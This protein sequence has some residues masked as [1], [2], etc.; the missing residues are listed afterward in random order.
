MEQI[1]ILHTNDLH[2]HFENWPRI[3]RYL[4]ATQREIQEQ[5]QTVLT[6][7]LGDH[8][9][10]VHPLTEATGGHINVQLLNQ[11]HYDGVTIGNNEGLGFNHA[12]LDHLYDNANFDVI[13]GDIRDE[14]TNR[15]P[16]WAID[17]KLI[18]EPSGTRILV[19]GLTAPYLLTYP[20]VGWRPESVMAAL[21]ELLD[22]YRD[23]AD[24]CIL[25]S[26]LGLD[27]D[28]QI[29]KRFPQIQIIIGSHTHH[30]LENGEVVNDSLL[31]AAGKWGEYVGRIDLSVDDQHQL[32]SASAS[33]TAVRTLPVLAEDQSEIDHYEELGEELLSEREIA[34]LPMPMVA[35]PKGQPQIITVGLQAIAEY[36]HTDAAILNSGLFLSGLP[37]G[38]V[39]ANQL[40]Q[41]LPHA[42]HVMKVTLTGYDVW[43]LVNEME[44]CRQFLRHFPIK[45]MGFRGKIFGEINYLGIQFDETTGRVTW[46]GEDLNPHRRYTIAMLDNYLFIPFFPTIKLVGTAE[47]LFNQLLRDVVGH[48]LAN[49]YPI[50]GGRRKTDGS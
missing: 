8:C 4:Q 44:S 48:Y 25:L 16:D 9:D 6:F 42:I 40:H 39:N 43:R 38:I 29:A 34:A 18:T 14:K 15:V 21:S 1:T 45:G 49:H 37:E 22:A 13:L 27:V 47:I 17:H 33:V 31:A 20:L 26:H 30:L 10:R 36:A 2:S 24:L 12:Q 3:R 23:R 5:H 41:I 32:V 7:D 11:I 46:R 50:E 19:L 28:R 35:Q